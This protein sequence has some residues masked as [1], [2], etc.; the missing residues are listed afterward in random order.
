MATPTLQPEKADTYTVG[1]VL[2][3]VALPALSVSVDYY[4]IKIDDT[5]TS[6]T[7]N[8]MIAELRADR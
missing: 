6:L 4:D 3:P 2:Q 8:T 7:S 5:I 1:F